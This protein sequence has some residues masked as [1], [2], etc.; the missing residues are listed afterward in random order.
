[1]NVNVRIRIKQIGVL[2]ILAGSLALLPT[3]AFAWSIPGVTRPYDP[4]AY[5]SPTAISW[6]DSKPSIFTMLD[7]ARQGGRVHDYTE[8]KNDTNKGLKT[9][10]EQLRR[11][12][13]LWNEIKNLTP[14]AWGG[15]WQ[16][17]AEPQ[18]SQKDQAVFTRTENENALLSITDSNGSDLK[19]TEEDKLRYL[20]TMYRSIFAYNQESSQSYTAR[21]GLLAKS[22]AVSA[23]AEGQL[24]ALQAQVGLEGSQA[25]EN[26][27]RNRLIGL[28]NALLAVREQS[29]I[30]EMV[31][32]QAQNRRNLHIQFASPYG[33]SASDKAVFTK[34]KAPGMP[35]FSE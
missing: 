31:R 11:L 27:Q 16:S 21:T 32:V 2:G 20:D 3:N 15:F 17:L 22:L 8:E 9:T 4:P 25:A 19:K 10:I 24:A 26:L 23:S 1:M 12:D 14:A 13:E 7:L 28:Q 18:V 30:D 35:D 33:Q 6:R 34:P 5:Y 29:K